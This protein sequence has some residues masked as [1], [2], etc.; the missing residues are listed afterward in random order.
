MLEIIVTTPDDVVARDDGNLDRDRLTTV[1]SHA[2]RYHCQQQRAERR[3]S[4]ET[5]DGI[6]LNPAFFTL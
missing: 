4:H 1:R 3:P 6:A 5:E 2:T